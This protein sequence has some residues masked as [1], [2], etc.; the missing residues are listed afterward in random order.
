MAIVTLVDAKGHAVVGMGRDCNSSTAALKAI[1]S[2]SNRL[3]MV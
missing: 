3:S 1:V 2:A